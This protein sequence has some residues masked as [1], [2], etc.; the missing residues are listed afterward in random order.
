M[1]RVFSLLLAVLLANTAVNAQTSL[2]ADL[3]YKVKNEGFAKSQIESMSQFMTD[4]MGPRLAASQLKLRAERIGYDN[5]DCY[6]VCET[7]LEDIMVH[8]RNVRPDILI[9]DSIQTIATDT[10]ESSAGSVAQVRECTAALLRFAK[11]LQ[12]FHYCF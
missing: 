2:P 6:I 5:P 3:A 7:M 1:K 9:V 4:N 11:H 8:V 10:L 12:P